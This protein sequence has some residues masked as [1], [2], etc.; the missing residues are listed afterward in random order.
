MDIFTFITAYGILIV[1][2]TLLWANVMS[3]LFTIVFSIVGVYKIGI[4]LSRIIGYYFFVS[5]ASQITREV[6][7][8]RESLPIIIFYI[9]IGAYLVFASILTGIFSKLEY[10]QKMTKTTFDLLRYQRF[11]GLANPNL[12][13]MYLI[14][15]TVLFILFT[16]VPI[17][18]LNPITSFFVAAIID[19]IKNYPLIAV[20]V[21]IVGANQVK[22]LLFISPF[23]LS[24]LIY[25]LYKTLFR[26]DKSK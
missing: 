22:N 10:E 26:K 11:F 5:I 2:H 15:T 21:A 19:V 20:I 6:I 23:V 17:F 9:S 14:G 13:Y 12:E 24:Y 8:G 7:G 3:M 4:H 16:I 25:S 1:L 18:T